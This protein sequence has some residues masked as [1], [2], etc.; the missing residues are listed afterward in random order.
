MKSGYPS[1]HGREISVGT[2]ERPVALLR[3]FVSLSRSQTGG[4]RVLRCRLG[5]P[6]SHAIEKHVVCCGEVGLSEG[7]TCN[8]EPPKWSSSY[9]TV[10]NKNAKL[11]KEF[12]K[13]EVVCWVWLAVGLF[14]GASP[15]HAKVLFRWWSARCGVGCGLLGSHAEV[16]FEVCVHRRAR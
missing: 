16:L 1:G 6:S 15:S 13:R 10:Q 14:F 4:C 8:F 9:G 3:F 12:G 2:A 11:T 5:A 7:L